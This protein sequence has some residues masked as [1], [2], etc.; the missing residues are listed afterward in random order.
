MVG[1]FRAYCEFYDPDTK[2]LVPLYAIEE[3]IPWL[4]RE[5]VAQGTISLMTLGGWEIVGSVPNRI[6][7]SFWRG[8]AVH[9]TT[10]NNEIIFTSGQAYDPERNSDIWKIS[11][12]KTANGNIALP[13]KAR[14]VGKL[15][16]G[17]DNADVE[18]NTESHDQLFAFNEK[19]YYY[20][21]YPN[22]KAG[23]QIDA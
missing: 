9:T 2:R 16:D 17:P 8:K 12:E 7:P 5:G 4:F 13:V 10:K 18:W 22:H 11:M 6:A 20:S 3:D 15:T 23:F 1:E 19:I 14:K 21:G